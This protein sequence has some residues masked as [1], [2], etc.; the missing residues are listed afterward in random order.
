MIFIKQ[1]F[2]N[3][4]VVDVPSLIQSCT[5]ERKEEKDRERELTLEEL[6]MKLRI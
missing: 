5:R 3:L 1:A 2:S 6:L 4:L